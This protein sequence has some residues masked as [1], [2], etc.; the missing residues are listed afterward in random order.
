MNTGEH[1]AGPK[2]LRRLLESRKAREERENAERMREEGLK[3][4]R[5]KAERRKEE[6]ERKALQIAE[7]KMQKAKLEEELKRAKRDAWVKCH[8]GLCAEV[9]APGNPRVRDLERWIGRLA[10]VNAMGFACLQ[11]IKEM[12]RG[13][14]LDQARAMLRLALAANVV[15]LYERDEEVVVA[16]AEVEVE[17]KKE[18][19]KGGGAEA[20]QIADCRLQSA[21]CADEGKE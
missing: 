9:A 7:C 10:G 2:G 5:V 19:T 3:A 1:G 11:D 6:E 17:V 16:Q 13:L 8:V 14:H 12:I 15:A 18:E 20:R 4:E 21:K